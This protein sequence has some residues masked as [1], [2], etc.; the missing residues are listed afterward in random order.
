MTKFFKLSESP[1]GQARPILP[2]PPL[3]L[4]LE[5]EPEL[6][7]EEDLLVLV[8][9]LEELVEVCLV[10]VEVF[11]WVVEVGLADD[12]EVVGALQVLLLLREAGSRFWTT[13]GSAS[14]SSTARAM[15]WWRAARRWPSVTRAS[16]W[17]APKEVAKMARVEMARRFRNLEAAIV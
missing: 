6:E 3:P 1:L 12:E 16:A 4:L 7:E 5:D 14:R 13:A 15:W 8:D 11:L 17:V 10:E 2:D 9:F